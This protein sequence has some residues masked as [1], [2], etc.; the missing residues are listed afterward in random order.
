MIITILSG[1]T[2]FSAGA[3]W[4]EVQGYSTGN[5]F[6]FKAF[7]VSGFVTLISIRLASILA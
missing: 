6:W 3:G 2:L 1:I 5:Y 7:L 4:A